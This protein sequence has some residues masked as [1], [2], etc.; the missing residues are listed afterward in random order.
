MDK[1]KLLKKPPTESELCT[2]KN[3][4]QCPVMNKCNSENEIYKAVVPSEKNYNMSYIGS[5]QR[6]FKNK[7]YEHRKSF[8]KH[9]KKRATNCTQ[10]ANYMWKLCEKIEKLIIN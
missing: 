10:F 8:P 1:K 4:R 7:L 9:K 2:C 5:T 6:P 3:K